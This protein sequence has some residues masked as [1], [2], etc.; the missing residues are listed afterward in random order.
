L[1]QDDGDEA[2]SRLGNEASG[3]MELQRGWIAYQLGYHLQNDGLIKKVS[4]D[5]NDPTTFSIRD[6]PVTNRGRIEVVSGILNLTTL[7]QTDG[8]TRIHRNAF[9]NL[10]NPLTLQG[11]KLTGAGQLNGAVANSTGERHLRRRHR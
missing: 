10:S 4:P 11:G 1:A 6:C 7:T 2:V 8:E 5:P 3:V 9:L